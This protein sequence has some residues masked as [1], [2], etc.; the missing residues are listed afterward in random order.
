MEVSDLAVVVDGLDHPEGVAT[1][2]D[3]TL[4]AGG[5]AGQL[6]RVDAD[7]GTFEQVADCGGFLLGLAVDGDGFVYAC[8]LGLRVV[9]RIDPSS[10]RVE[11]LTEGAPGRPLVNPNWPV[12][13][14]YG[15]LLVTD[16]GGWQTGDGAVLAVEPD[17]TTTVWS[18]EPGRFPN[19]ACL[20]PE[21][22]ALLVL[23]SL[24]PALSRIPFEEGG[25]AGAMKP[26]ADLTGTIPDGVTVDTE[27]VAYVCCYRPDRILTVTP[28]G[29]VDV[30]V[31]DPAGTALA[32]PTNAVWT[33]PH[34]DRLVVG[35]LG[36][37]HLAGLTPGTRG[38]DVLR[39]SFGGMR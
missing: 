16:S 37:W 24:A 7:A 27:G 6:Y 22:D 32:A 3:G 20:T 35:N 34:L 11:V 23:E 8:N 2:A 31:D 28:D 21:R 13:D 1:A 12:F 38:V 36:R 25:A 9:Q 14:P 4:Y 18:D 26:V 15:R 30:L 29:R 19:G 17:G 10:G 33:G 5:E 39:P